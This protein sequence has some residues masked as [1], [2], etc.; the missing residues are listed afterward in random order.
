MGHRF[1][2]LESLRETQEEGPPES[3][4]E[5]LEAMQQQ[6]A[7]RRATAEGLRWEIGEVVQQ[8]RSA[9]EAELRLLAAAHG[10]DVEPGWCCREVKIG[11]ELRELRAE[12]VASE[13][14]GAELRAL[15]CPAH[16]S[17]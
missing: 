13:R 14:H 12:V 7:S 8:E 9:Q 1:A 15:V 10:G 16:G 11:K 6:L 2:E 17:C 4:R 3:V 5:E